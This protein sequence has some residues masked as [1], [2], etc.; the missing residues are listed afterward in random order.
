MECHTCKTPFAFDE[1]GYCTLCQQRYCAACHRA[2]GHALVI[3]NR[4]LLMRST[5]KEEGAFC[6]HHHRKSLRL[7]LVC[8]APHIRVHDGLLFTPITLGGTVRA[9][10]EEESPLLPTYTAGFRGRH[11]ERMELSPKA[12]R[13]RRRE[14]RERGLREG[15]PRELR[16]EAFR[17][18]WRF[19]HNTN[20]PL[21]S[22]E[23]KH[24][25]ERSIP[26]LTRE[27][28][29]EQYDEEEA[30]AG[31][32][33]TVT[34]LGDMQVAYHDHNVERGAMEGN[35]A[36]RILE[37][38]QLE[39]LEGAKETC[40]PLITFSPAPLEETREWLRKH[41]DPLMTTPRTAIHHFTRNVEEHHPDDL[42]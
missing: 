29:K 22:S 16:M 33:P 7:F 3:G 38:L 11:P 1:L 25:E 41:F 18:R 12:Q 21:E 6:I 15:D 28:S 17:K 9:W 26:T 39:D 4:R 19:T 23:E 10:E 32:T 2:T 40:S 20:I 35:E 34:R 31:P 30:L 5:E 37:Q 24:G 36:S 27:A 42:R 8:P 13:K 14:E